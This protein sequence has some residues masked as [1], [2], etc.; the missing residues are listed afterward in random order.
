MKKIV[1]LLF[2]LL[3]GCDSPDEKLDHYFAEMNLL[4]AEPMSSLS[5]APVLAAFSYPESE[6]RRNPFKPMFQNS[7][8][9]SLSV[10][11]LHFIGTWKRGDMI[12][13]LLKQSNGEVIRVKA[14]DLLSQYDGKV[15]QV[16]Q[17][18]LQIEQT[19][20]GSQQHKIIQYNLSAGD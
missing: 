19:V 8:F 4:N 1:C 14:G 12:W 15:I 13:G 18:E 11:S 9:V 17:D 2:L 10:D 5:L 7:S 20:P 16:N 6:K 3:T